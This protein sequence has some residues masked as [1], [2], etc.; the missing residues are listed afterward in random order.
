MSALALAQSLNGRKETAV[1]DGDRKTRPRSGDGARLC[2][3]LRRSQR[4]LQRVSSVDVE[5]RAE[6][7]LPTDWVSRAKHVQL[8]VLKYTFVCMNMVSIAISA[9]VLFMANDAAK[10]WTPPNSLI[11]LGLIFGMI[12]SVIAIRGGLKEELYLVLTYSLVVACVYLL[13]LIYSMWATA[14]SAA[15]STAYLAVS[16]FYSLLLYLKPAKAVLPS[17][18]VSDQPL[19]MAS[20]A[21]VL[22]QR[23]ASCTSQS[24]QSSFAVKVPDCQQPVSP[25]DLVSSSTRSSNGRRQAPVSKRQAHERRQLFRET[26]AATPADSATVPRSR[27]DN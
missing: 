11:I 4:L 8:L 15:I 23:E 27:C 19:V 18:F 1:L 9:Y 13:C 10:L 5:S 25:S 6:S 22:Q 2:H 21:T 16:L 12:L 26:P 14:S 3:K 24:S 7:L 20:A 17:D